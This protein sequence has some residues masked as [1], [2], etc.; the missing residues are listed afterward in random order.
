MKVEWGWI[1][2]T[3]LAALLLEAMNAPGELKTLI[4]LSVFLQILNRI[5]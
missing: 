5:L 3:A 4:W 2:I 1:I